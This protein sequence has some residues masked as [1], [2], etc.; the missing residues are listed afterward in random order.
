MLAAGCSTG[1][2]RRD[3]SLA[4]PEEEAPVADDSAGDTGGGAG[5]G[6]NDENTAGTP[7]TGGS[8]G[9]A[10]AGEPEEPDDPE[11]GAAGQTG[12]EP[13]DTGGMGGTTS[14]PTPDPDPVVEPVDAPPGFFLVPGKDIDLG[15]PNDGNY[16]LPKIEDGDDN[17]GF[18]KL[19]NGVMYQAPAEPVSMEVRDVDEA[20]LPEWIEQAVYT[21]TESP[22]AVNL[23]WGINFRE[24]TGSGN[25]PWKSID[26]TQYASLEF[27]TKLLYPS[28]AALSAEKGIKVFLHDPTGNDRTEEVENFNGLTDWT[29]VTI[30]LD[31]QTNNVDLS[32]LGKVDL[33]VGIEDDNPPLEWWIAGMRLIE[34][35]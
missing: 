23:I 18:M 1:E 20:D 6:S 32:Q 10:G 8:G 11:A 16:N 13:S 4:E 33:M 15:Q 21:R 2:T 34:K 28:D 27:Y 3:L 30:N 9:T 31:R 24:E 7:D 29:K 35:D 26:A 12:E 25:R 17:P 5:N 19:G 22:G 14:D